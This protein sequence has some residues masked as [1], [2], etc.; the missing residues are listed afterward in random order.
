MYLRVALVAWICVLGAP[1]FAQEP[2][3]KPAAP[4]PSSSIVVEASLGASFLQFGLQERDSKRVDLGFLV[5]YRRNRLIVG[6]G[7]DFASRG[8]R[9][10][11]LVLSPVVQYAFVR[12]KDESIELL[13]SG[14]VGLGFDL[15]NVRSVENS[16]G[17]TSF[18]VGYKVGP[19]LRVWSGPEL[20]WSVMSGICG[21]H[22]HVVGSAGTISTHI[23]T[24][25]SFG[26]LGT[27]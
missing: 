7:L 17:G 1:C 20:A 26:V 9:E 2:P 24:Y 6:G 15:S 21:D 25:T 14:R 10:V 22:P 12:S 18:N 19:V 11:E 13:I 16:T 23:G 5:G 3:P 27:F 8:H 4:Q